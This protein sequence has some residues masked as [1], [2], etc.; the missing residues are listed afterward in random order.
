[1]PRPITK[2]SDHIAK[3]FAA[4]GSVA[5]IRKAVPVHVGTHIRET[6][7]IDNRTHVRVLRGFRIALAGLI[8]CS[9]TVAD[10]RNLLSRHVRLNGRRVPPTR[11]VVFG[12]QHKTMHGNS[13]IE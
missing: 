9:P 13:G 12:K 2:L 4:V 7:R 8:G 1:M 6:D 5:L 10:L 3:N 11:F